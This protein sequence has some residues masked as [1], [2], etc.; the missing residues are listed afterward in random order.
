MAVTVSTTTK[1]DSRRAQILEHA[2]HL[3]GTRGF[4]RTSI[5][6]IAAAVGMLPGSVYYHFASKE[7][8]LAAVY[9]DAI[10]QAIAS[11]QDAAALHQ[12]PWDRLEAAA[13][14]HMHTLVGGGSLA[15]VVT[16]SPNLPGAA[17][18]ELI[19][20]R[21][22]YEAVFRALVADLDLPPGIHPS[23]FRLALLGAL[24][25]AL[26]WYRPGGRS[27]EDVARRL[28]AVFR[29]HQLATLHPHESKPRL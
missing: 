10:D 11:V 1:P 13:V 24:N 2:A 26:T 7:A 23:S 27:P 29:T 25:W 14:A 28:F 18:E 9:T 22:R 4:D 21:H 17:R 16:D 15:V 8:L 19:R 12:D 20:Q 5:R 6:D 3:F